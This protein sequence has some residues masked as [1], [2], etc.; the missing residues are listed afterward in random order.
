MSSKILRRRIN[1][2]CN[3]GFK[4][5]VDQ[6]WTLKIYF[7]SDETF[8]EKTFA[9]IF[10][11]KLN[12]EPTRAP[13]KANTTLEPANLSILLGQCHKVL[14]N[15]KPPKAYLRTKVNIPRTPHKLSTSAQKAMYFFE[16]NGFSL[17]PGYTRKELQQAF[18][19]LAKKMHPDFNHENT[20]EMFIR[21]RESYH[22]LL[23]VCPPLP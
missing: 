21:L 16:S 13:L 8:M 18:R 11:A 19:K 22:D 10:L 23:K 9:E 6:I 20:N 5:L 15:T 12:P 4:S 7:Y 1:I 3:S 14:F 2:T 17:D